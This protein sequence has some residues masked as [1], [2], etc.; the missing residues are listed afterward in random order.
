MLQS[1]R[2]RE[3]YMTE[4]LNDN[5]NLTTGVTLYDL[6]WALRGRYTLLIIQKRKTEAQRG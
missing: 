6:T 2:S 1:M 3:S 5:N 4:Q